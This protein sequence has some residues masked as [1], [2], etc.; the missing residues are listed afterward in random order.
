M[1][2]VQMFWPLCVECIEF[3]SQRRSG[4]VLKKS[5]HGEGQTDNRGCIR[6]KGV[7]SVKLWVKSHL[8]HRPAIA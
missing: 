4:A 7:I 3:S 8:H 2:N 6:E 1:S 5:R